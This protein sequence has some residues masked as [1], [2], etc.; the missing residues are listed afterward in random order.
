[1]SEDKENFDTFNDSNSNDEGIDN[2]EAPLNLEGFKE[3][4]DEHFEVLR[5]SGLESGKLYLESSRSLAII[6]LEA[7]ANKLLSQVKPELLAVYKICHT[8]S[9]RMKNVDKW[10]G[11]RSNA[12]RAVFCR[13]FNDKN[14]SKLEFISGLAVM[15]AAGKKKVGSFVEF[16]VDNKK[17]KIFVE[18]Q[19]QGLIDFDEVTGVA[20]KALV[21]GKPKTASKRKGKK[22][23]QVETKI[24]D[25]AVIFRDIVVKYLPDKY[26]ELMASRKDWDSV[27]TDLSDSSSESPGSADAVDN[28]ASDVPRD[29]QGD[30]H[31][32]DGATAES[33]PESGDTT[34]LVPDTVDDPGSK[35]LEVAKETVDEAD[36]EDSVIGSVDEAVEDTTD[37]AVDTM[38]S[39]S[40][41]LQSDDVDLDDDHF[42]VGDRIKE[43]ALETETDVKVKK[44]RAARSIAPSNGIHG[45]TPYAGGAF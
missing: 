5:D 3:K 1:M 14:K 13:K 12:E 26:V 24:R 35:V 15:K 2:K 34:T 44:V 30:I 10:W 40:C 45:N 28:R 11:T 4:F 7:K 37:A 16:R 21:F 8:T 42:I 18:L 36:V 43:V 23:E 32:N 25:Q 22:L 20:L 9:E 17:D 33:I 39:V 31:A 41:G 19:G 29:V 6:L 27:F 38:P